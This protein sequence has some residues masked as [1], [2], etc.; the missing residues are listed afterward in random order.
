M[1]AETSHVL[2]WNRDGPAAP[3]RL[4]RED[5]VIAVGTPHAIE[6]ASN[7]NDTGIKIEPVLAPDDREC[8]TETKAGREEKREERT[9]EAPTQ[10][11]VVG[12]RR[13]HDRR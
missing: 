12:V 11:S 2:R 9:R 10:A 6:A 4:R 1:P 13:G 7:M 5:S 8:L 3:S